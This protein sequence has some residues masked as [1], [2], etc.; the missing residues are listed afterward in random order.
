[1]AVTVN[2]NF[3]RARL[4]FANLIIYTHVIL[5]IIKISHVP[6]VRCLRISSSCF[7]F[8]VAKAFKKFIHQQDKEYDMGCCTSEDR[9]G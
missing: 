5:P 9:E 2:R 4:E 3:I 6:W 1:M 8:R 7:F